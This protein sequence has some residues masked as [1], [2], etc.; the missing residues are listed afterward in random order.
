MTTFLALVFG[1]ALLGVGVGY[2][3][4]ALLVAWLHWSEGIY[5]IFAAAI[6]GAPVGAV[7]LPPFVWWRGQRRR[8]GGGR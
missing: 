8:R 5:G 1:G 2:V 6:L 3:V 7:A 4:G